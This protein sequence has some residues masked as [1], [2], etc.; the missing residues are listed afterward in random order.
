[1]KKL[2]KISLIMILPLLLGGCAFL[3]PSYVDNQSVYSI[4]LDHSKKLIGIDQSSEIKATAYTINKDL[5]T[6]QTF[7]WNTSKEGIIELEIYDNY[8]SFTAK[9]VGTVSLK[10]SS[11]ENEKAF[12]TCEIE[13]T[14]E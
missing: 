1:M 2:S 7:N 9:S 13:V 10:C 6:N 14:N 3:F 12:T 5:A 8:V 11:K 4:S